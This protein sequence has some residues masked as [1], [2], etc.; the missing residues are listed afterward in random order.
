MAEMRSKDQGYALLEMLLVLILLSG[1]GFVLLIKLPINFERQ[2][3]AFTT[4]QLL[5]EIRDT[6]QAALAENN[7]YQFKFYVQNG[8]HNYKIFRQGT[9][10]KD[11]HLQ[12]EIKFVGAEGFYL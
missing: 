3:L 2:N 7:W 11:V 8:D 1:A 6:R 5:E 10:V 12:E 4:T 9:R